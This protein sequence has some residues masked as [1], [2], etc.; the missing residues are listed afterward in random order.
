MAFQVSPGVNI[1]EIDQTSSAPAVAT[2]EGAIAGVFRWGPMN[3][4]VLVDSEGTLAG[5]FG[6]PT[7]FNA[8]T[9]FTAASFLA[10]GNKLYVVRA[11]NTSYQATNPAA[12][13]TANT[14]AVSANYSNGSSNASFYPTAVGS[15]SELQVA[16]ATQLASVK[17]SDEYE[18][19]RSNLANHPGVHFSARFPGE[20]GNSLK[21][22]VC[23][24]VNAFSSSV[25]VNAAVE[26]DVTTHGDSIYAEYANTAASSTDGSGTGA[27]FTVRRFGNGDYTVATVTAGG[28]GYANGDEITIVGSALG[29]ANTTNDITF[30]VTTGAADTI[31]ASVNTVSGTANAIGTGQFSIEVGQS[32]G[33]FSIPV[34][35][36]AAVISNTDLDIFASAQAAFTLGDIWTVGNTTIGTADLKLKSFGTWE[37]NA[38]HTRVAVQFENRWQQR[39]GYSTDTIARSWEFYNSVDKA[40]SATA[41]IIGLDRRDA[42]NALIRDGMHVVVTD[43]DGKISGAPGTILEVYNNISR[44]TDART[45]EGDDNYYKN[46]LRDN[47]QWVWAFNDPTGVTSAAAA[48]ITN[49]SAALPASFSM[50]GGDDG[51]SEADVAEGTVMSAYDLFR[52]A[53]EVDISLI[54]TGRAKGGTNGE[55]I[56]NYVIDNVA[57]NR[58]DCLVFVSPAKTDVVTTGPSI[59]DNVIAF[60]NSLTN[61][62]YAVMDSGYKYMYDR[63]NDVYRWVPLNGDIAG[64]AVRTDETRDPWFSPA[65]LQRGSIRNI[66]KLAY[67]PTKGDR[68]KLYKADVNPVITIPGQGTVLFGD[69]TL[70]GR[71]SP[72]DR[73][74]VRRLFIVLEKT[75]STAAKFTLFEFNDEFTR[76]QFKNLVEPFLRDVQGRRGIYDFRVVCDETN[77]TQAVVDSNQFVGDIYIK[78]ARSINF[79]QLNFVAVRSGVEFSEIVGSE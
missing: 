49:S 13:A 11:G 61:S 41:S 58:R 48:S 47:S 68:D 20:L 56:A 70:I 31:V 36:A 19:A 51:D 62:S 10:Y 34:P 4:R 2:T 65:G 7:S 6:K 45:E 66:V 76:A 69:K 71:P 59:A 18:D 53:E 30:V 40:P 32:Q 29:G 60:R 28:T 1:T 64:L 16:Y 9:F 27:R 23:A 26:D 50:T 14:L 12:S 54:V 55:L 79:I 3:Q 25:D 63:Y 33:H 74:N 5:L 43:E 52:N 37:A 39:A 44:A 21:I 8:E 24:S 72:F 15:N 22:S 35:L 67:N 38:T 46:I 17:N 42:N 78:P 57:G 75:V 73:I 77:N